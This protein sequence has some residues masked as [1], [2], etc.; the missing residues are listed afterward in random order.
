MR[1]TYC[2]RILTGKD[3]QRPELKKRYAGYFS[4]YL[5]RKI[6]ASCHSEQSEEPSQSD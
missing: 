4:A 5:T 2:R 3:W 6:A 1:R